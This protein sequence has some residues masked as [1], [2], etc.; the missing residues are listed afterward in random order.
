M[1]YFDRI[2]QNGAPLLYGVLKGFIKMTFLATFYKFIMEFSKIENPMISFNV[3]AGKLAF[4][5]F[6]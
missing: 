4:V 5:I 6:C 2:G 3:L 1:S